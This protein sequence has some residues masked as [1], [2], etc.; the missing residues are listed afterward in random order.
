[1]PDLWTADELDAIERRFQTREVLKERASVT[2][3]ALDVRRAGAGTSG[4]AKSR[5][6]AA[7][8]FRAGQYIPAAVEHDAKRAS[9]TTE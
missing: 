4:G 7:M 2:S 8:P 6:H 5:P 3:A 9:V 1:V